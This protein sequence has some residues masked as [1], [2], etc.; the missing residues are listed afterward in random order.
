MKLNNDCAPDGLV[1]D[2][3]LCIVVLGYKLKADGSMEDE[4]VDRLHVAKASAEK[5]PNSFIFVSGGATADNNKNETEAGQMSK[6]LEQQG[7]QGSRIIKDESA[8][9]ILQNAENTYKILRDS[10]KQVKNLVLVSSDYH[11]KRASLLYHAT[12]QKLANKNADS[13][14]SIVSNACAQTSESVKEKANESIQREAKTL[15]QI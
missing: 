15:A 14:L 8:M 13:K 6:W 11:I 3:S 9:T 4:L 1:G 2:D 5:Y 10:H 7:I 12:I